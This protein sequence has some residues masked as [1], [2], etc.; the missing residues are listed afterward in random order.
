MINYIKIKGVLNMSDI[1][2]SSYCGDNKCDNGISP[3]LLV[4]MLLLCG[5]DNGLC[6]GNGGLF[7]G[8][9]SN[10]DCGCNNGFGGIMPILLILLLGGGS[11]C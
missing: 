11:F 1:S 4:L 6:G 10:N 3:M 8:C 7:G 9:N 5:G 2:T